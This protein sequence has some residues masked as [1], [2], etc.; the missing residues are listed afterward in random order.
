MQK[1]VLGFNHSGLV[2]KNLDSMVK[3]YAEILGLQVIRKIDSEAPV[4]GDHTGIS[5]ARRELVF[6]GKP[7]GEHLLELVHY[8]EPKS[9]DGHL[10]R[11]QLGASHICFDVSGLDLLY[12]RLVQQGVR[13][14]T[15]PKAKVGSDGMT[16]LVCYIQD[17]EGNWLELIEV[18][19]PGSI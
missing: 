19:D 1:L 2:V 4:T 14:V 17:P 18:I 7:E 3:F 5:G 8:L 13:F 11:N 12:T 10:R 16:T 9:E 6:M 15:P